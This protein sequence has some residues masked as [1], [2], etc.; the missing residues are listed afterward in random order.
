MAALALGVLA[1]AC[2]GAVIAPRAPAQ[3]ALEKFNAVQ[4]KINEASSREGVLTTTIS[5]Y[6]DHIDELRGQVAELRNRE[7]VV[8]ARLQKI[9][10]EL[11]VEEQQLATLR[12]QLKRSI[13]ALSDRLVD[14]YKSNDPDILTVVLDS[15][16]FDDLLERSDYLQRIQNQ[17]SDFVG[18]VRELRNQTQQIVDRITAQRDEVAAQKAE[19]DRTRAQLQSRSAEFA[20]ARAKQR[21]ALAS[22][23][24]HRDD[25][26]GDLSEISKQVQE[27]LLGSSPLPAGPIHGA[28]GGFIWPVNGPITSGFGFRGGRMHAGVDIGVPAGTPIRA[29]KAGTVVLA[30]PTGGYGNY[31]CIDHG[32]GL[33][34]CY[35]HQ[36][37]FARTSGPI[38]QGDVLG[39]VGCTGHCFGDHLHFEIRFNGEATDPLAYL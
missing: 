11:N 20:Q 7:A 31:T 28:A 4:S 19:L 37:S 8:V 15:K 14:I 25:L 32:G 35:A 9:Q 6:N 22:T 10:A 34:T 29:A 1:A 13:A 23:R 24:E 38:S 26:E 30:G 39:Y 5:R 12:E 21:K 18:R 2:A 33:S 17:E 27:Q 16:G 36:S 3:S